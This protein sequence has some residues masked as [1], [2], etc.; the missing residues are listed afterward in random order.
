MVTSSKAVL[1]FWL[2][3][4]RRS[5]YRATWQYR[6]YLIQLLL[7]LHDNRKEKFPVEYFHSVRENLTDRFGGVTAFVRSPA[8]GLWK[9][10][11]ED[12]SHDEV[13]MFEVISNELNEGWWEEYRIKLQEKFRQKELLVWATSISALTGPADSLPLLSNWRCRVRSRLTRK[14]YC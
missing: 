13:V 1:G 4:V 8:V 9:D 11:V 2:V 12:V 5:N 7:P 10:D 3:S 14:S 6:M